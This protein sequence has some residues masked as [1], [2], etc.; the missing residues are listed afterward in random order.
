MP[1]GR[2][3]GYA[4][5]LFLSVWRQ[6]MK[7]T[8]RRAVVAA[9][10]GLV[11]A[12]TPLWAQFVAGRPVQP[13]ASAAAV[14]ARCPMFPPTA[15]FNQRLD[16]VTRFPVHARSAVWLDSIGR[17]KALHPDWGT[18]ED[19]QRHTSYYGIPYNRVTGAAAT[20]E[21]LPMAYE[22]VDPRETSGRAN[23]VPEES[24][25]AVP[26]ASAPN[27]MRLQRGCDRV[28][29]G[30]RRFPFPLP[31]DLKA[32]HGACNDAQTCGDRHV[33]VLEEG[34]GGVCR[35]WES[36][37]AYRQD[38]HWQSYSTAAW[39]L[40]SPQI[41]PAGWTSADA[42]GLPILPLLARADEASSGEIH[43]ALRVTFHSRV[44]DRRY[45]WPAS[46][47]AG[48]KKDGAIPFGAVLRLRADFQV[49]V[50]WTG[51]A[52]ALAMAMKRH[53][54]IVAD[55]GSD[56]FVQGEPSTQWSSLTAMQLRML[57]LDQFE[58]VDLTSITRD[59]RF[60]ADSYQAA[61]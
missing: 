5:G 23:G 18:S 7:I 46:H 1:T 53:G 8:V 52:Q 27:G 28:A 19:Q 21:W 36:Y 39:D 33:L 54:L 38:G 35:L 22:I 56:F 31:Q 2:W 15:I 49:P 29:P 4:A 30:Q 41:R 6:T 3:C 11:A 10:L 58:F 43:H 40:R 12:G 45:E 47:G 26:D 57:K 59:P 13:A 48:I 50:W 55:I 42:G 25:C 51:Q 44:L 24:D 14:A 16:D 60:R 37:F 34:E 20:T 61:W 32:E 17:G 9:A